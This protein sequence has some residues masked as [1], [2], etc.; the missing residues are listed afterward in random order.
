[1]P[2]QD[3]T[4]DLGRNPMMKPY[5]DLPETSD[6]IPSIDPHPTPPDVEQAKQTF[7]AIEATPLVESPI[8]K[9]R[10]DYLWILTLTITCIC[11]VM[12]A[13]IFSILRVQTD[14]L[15]SSNDTRKIDNCRN[16]YNAKL[17]QTAAKSRQVLGKLVSD[18]AISAAN[19]TQVDKLTFL[20]DAQALEQ[21]TADD[22]AAVTARDDWDAAGQPLPCPITPVGSS[23]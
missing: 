2:I 14:Q 10:R 23:G 8:T 18:V 19:A 6:E 1:M 9:R 13:V 20:G 22:I 7:H 15:T 11:G 4:P 21:A 5:D 12:S 3:P 17:S 16:A